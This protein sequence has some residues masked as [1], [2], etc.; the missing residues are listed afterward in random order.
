MPVPKRS[1][2]E[3]AFLRVVSILKGF[4]KF[5]SGVMY[6]GLPNKRNEWNKHVGRK[7]SQK[8]INGLFLINMLGGNFEMS[9]NAN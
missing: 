7:F 9:I 3:V 5:L 8:S 1:S 6:S 4:V 2:L